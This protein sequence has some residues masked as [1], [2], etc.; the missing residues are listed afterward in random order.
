MEWCEEKYPNRTNVYD[1]V[2]EPFRLFPMMSKDT[3][4]KRVR[5]EDPVL[6]NLF[7]TQGPAIDSLLLSQDKYTWR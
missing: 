2:E 3:M 1:T 5:K 6:Y 4:K 7:V